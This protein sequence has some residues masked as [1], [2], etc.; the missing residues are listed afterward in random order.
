MIKV[1][2]I[3]S[4]TNV[5]SGVAN[6]VMNYYR[7]IDRENIQFD[8]LVFWQAPKSFNDEI[9][10]LGG[11][12]YYFTKPGFKTYSKAKRELREFFIAHKDE[13]EIVHC[14]EIL[15]AK[16]VFSTAR[17][18]GGN[19]KCISHSHNSRLA[20]GCLKKIR[21]RLLV[22][23]LMKKSDYCFACSKEAAV[24]AFGK[25]V[26]N[27]DKYRLIYNAINLGKFKFSQDARQRV[28]N[29]LN[30]DGCLVLGNVGRLCYQKNQIFALK[31]LQELL[32]SRGDVKLL[33]VGEGPDKQ[34]LERYV[35]DNSLN[36]NVIFTGIR[37]DIPD[38]LSAIDYFVFPS[39]YEGLGIA[40]VEAQASGLICLCFNDLPDEVFM[41]NFIHGFK[42]I[43]QPDEW[44]TLILRNANK[45]I[46]RSEG[47][48]FIKEKGFD[49][50]DSA[51]QLEKLYDY[52]RNS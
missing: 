7:N 48:C 4:S 5:N 1:L 24:S 23:N 41:S 29:E 45:S 8:F 15:V 34:T 12:V 32:K 27:S 35:K 19:P 21:N 9:E 16:T 11:K 22:I 33:L 31:V 39:V 52:I 10:S 47:Y 44:S 46:D 50:A 38:I 14:H 17:K 28:R 18:Y 26:L 3:L 43:S 42:K 51:K 13:Y 37:K 25:A 6:V 30:L 20:D 40:L 49:I 2:Q 36:N